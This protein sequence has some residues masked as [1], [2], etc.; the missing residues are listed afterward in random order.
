MPFDHSASSPEDLLNHY[1]EK[2]R[3]P[4]PIAKW[5]L[6]RFFRAIAGVIKSFDRSDRILEVGCGPGESSLQIMKMLDGQHYEVSEYDAGLVDLL[7]RANFPVPVS[8]ESVYALDRADD[9]FD[10]V[11]LL[12][13]LEHL[14]EPQAALKE[15]FR[16]ASRDVIISVP[17]EPIWRVMNMARGKYLCSF[18]NT[19]GHINHWNVRSIVNLVSEFG[20]CVEV[21]TPLPWIVLRFKVI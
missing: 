18:G 20:E 14:Q 1:S 11:M 16:V 10:C 17:N 12:E 2:Y 3:N 9:S 5:M 8:Q 21:R 7:N 4:N 19:P 15:L 6:A 13:V